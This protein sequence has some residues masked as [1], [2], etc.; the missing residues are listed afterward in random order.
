MRFAVTALLPP[1]RWR[2]RGGPGAA[3]GALS[4]SGASVTACWSR[5]SPVL[6]VTLATAL[7]QDR[8]LFPSPSP[9]MPGGGG[10]RDGASLSQGPS[11]KCR[12]RRRGRSR[13]GAW[14]PSR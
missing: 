1:D 11:S 5:P 3:A 12:C 10:A 6:A 7:P 4:V 8:A 13:G 9:P 14:G 2:A